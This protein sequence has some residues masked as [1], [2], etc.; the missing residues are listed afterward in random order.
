MI[1]E[2]GKFKFECADENH[3]FIPASNVYDFQQK[4]NKLVK[5]SSRFST[6][7]S[8]EFVTVHNMPYT[9]KK[10]DC[11]AKFHEYIIKGENP[12]IDGWKLI[13]TLEQ[14]HSEPVF[15]NAPDES[16]PAQFKTTNGQICNHCNTRRYRKQNFCIQHIE[17]GEYK[18]IGR[19]CLA[20]FLG[21]SDPKKIAAYMQHHQ[22]FL[23]AGNEIE[24]RPC[25]VGDLTFNLRMV[26]MQAAS[27]IRHKGWISGGRAKAYNDTIPFDSTAKYMCS[28]CWHMLDQLFPPTGEA[29]KNW[30]K[31][32]IDSD[33]DGATVDA[34]LAYITGSSNESDYIR[35][36][37]IIIN[38][39]FCLEKEF[40]FVTS[41]IGTYSNHIIKQEK[42]ETDN[43]EIANSAHVGEIKKR[44][45][46]TLTLKKVIIIGGMFESWLHT[47]VDSNGNSVKW[48][49]SNPP[50]A[51]DEGETYHVKATVKKHDEYNGIKQTLVNRVSII[52]EEIK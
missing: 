6:Q 18:I 17:S 4:M 10:I 38:D 47:F 43:K 32:P 5:K 12:C 11:I 39:G 25:N 48:F 29:K 42:F 24:D 30:V 40:G 22:Q 28:S 14:Q 49:S 35:N 34:A 31:L 19:N 36:L 41:I 33:V 51:M 2:I 9:Y 15:N 8:V 27:V 21:G 26:L 37:K 23:N 16:I 52:T 7:L 20:D 50:D 1:K 45:E 44:Q 46:L 3:F 13:G